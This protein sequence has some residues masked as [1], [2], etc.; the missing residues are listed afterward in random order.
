[1]QYVFEVIESGDI[2]EKTMTV[3]EMLSCKRDDGEYFLLP[4]GKA[5]RRI[6]IEQGGWRSSHAGWPMLDEAA[7][8]PPSAIA[9]N[10][11]F[12]RASGVPTSF[13]PDGRVIWTDRNHRK[14]G[15]KAL[16]MYDKNA[17]YGD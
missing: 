2:V 13:T 17:G 12:M 7:G 15:L 9:E 1:M 6:D 11:A 4:E 3:A 16:G 14:R 10:V 8:V 5:K